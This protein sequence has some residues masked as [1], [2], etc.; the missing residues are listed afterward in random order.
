MTLLEQVLFLATMNKAIVDYLS[1]PI[2]QRWPEFDTW[3]LLYVS[4]ATGIGLGWLAKINLFIDLVT[5][6]TAG[7]I[8][9]GILVGGGSNLIHGIFNAGVS[10]LKAA[11]AKFNQDWE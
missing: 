5:N 4:M 11:K 7:I 10:F 3:W 8:L 9:T 1:A 2:K 6:G